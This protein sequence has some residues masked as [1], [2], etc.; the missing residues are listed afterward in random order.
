MP[1]HIGYKKCQGRRIVE[2]EILGDTNEDRVDI[3]DKQCAMMRC[4]EAR[5]IQIYD[6]FDNDI[7]YD[8]ACGFYKHDEVGEIPDCPKYRLGQI[9]KPDKWDDNIDEVHTNGIHYFLSKEPAFYWETWEY[10]LDGIDKEWHENGRQKM[11]RGSKNRR[12]YVTV[13]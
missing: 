7:K 8:L 6:M 12:Y 4:S 11:L 5:V 9:A 10:C 3:V 1:N 13:R 2:L